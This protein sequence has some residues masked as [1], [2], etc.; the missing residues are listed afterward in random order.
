[1]KQLKEIIGV[2]SVLQDYYEFDKE[3]FKEILTKGYFYY[4]WDG[5]IPPGKSKSSDLSLVFEVILNKDEKEKLNKFYTA[6][7]IPAQS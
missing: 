3:G 1:M 4:S 7:N 5:V 2:I 6:H